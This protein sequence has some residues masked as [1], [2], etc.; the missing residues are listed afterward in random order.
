MAGSRSPSCA[1]T[2]QVINFWASWC[3]PC[4][5]EAPAFAAAATR[6][7]G[8]VV[9]LGVDIQDLNGPA[10]RFLRR[11]RVNY[12]SVRASESTTASYGL[13]GIPETYYLDARGHAVEHEIGEVTT[14]ELA[15]GITLLLKDSR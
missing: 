13:T 3:V 7:A 4:K 14:T 2:R 1:A 9:F 10:R 15:D 11:Y 8:R 6:Y 5:R 12:V